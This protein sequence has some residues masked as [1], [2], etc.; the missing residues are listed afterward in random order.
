MS[1]G[2]N[3]VSDYSLGLDSL[4]GNI[5]GLSD[6]DEE[7][8]TQKKKKRKTINLD[9]FREFAAEYL[10]IRNMEGRKVKFELN[11]VQIFLHAILDHITNDLKKPIRVVILK[12]R[13]EGISLYTLGRFFW[14]ISTQENRQSAIITHDPDSTAELFKNS[15]LFHEWLPEEMKG[16]LSYDNKNELAYQKSKSSIRVGTANK[17]HYGSG[18]LLNYVHVSEFG[19]MA[20]NLQRELMAS[21]FQCV[22]ES[23]GTEILVES[24]ACGYT[25]F[26]NLFNGAR[27]NYN[28]ELEDGKPVLVYRENKDIP[29]DNVWA[30]VFFPYYAFSAYKLPVKGRLIL[31]EEE[32]GLRNA[33]GLTDEHI[34]WRR[35]AIQNK[36]F[37]DKT[38][39]KQEYPVDSESCFLSSGGAPVFDIEAIGTLRR[40]ALPPICEY[41]IDT[42][43]GNFVLNNGSQETPLGSLLVWQEPKRQSVYFIGADPSEGIADGSRSS[44]HVIERRSGAVVATWHGRITPDEFGRIL[45]Y[46]GAR[47]GGAQIACERNNMGILTNSILHDMNYPNIFVEMVPEAPNRSKKRYGWVTTK[48]SRPL[49]IGTLAAC[50]KDETF[51]GN[52]CIQDIGTLEEMLAFEQKED[53]TTGAKSGRRDDRV[54]SLAIA[55]HTALRQQ[56]SE[57]RRYENSYFALV[58]RPEPVTTAR[59]ANFEPDFSVFN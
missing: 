6:L 32:I 21:I 5:I 31:T 7:A 57:W 50:L 13:R 30:S 49:I 52:N 23:L 42:K 28:I 29:A 35:S 40:N 26:Y 46:L 12:A 55:M 56:P 59:E 3:V 47:Y 36:C 27:H 8:E 22:P 14:Q 19:K 45:F 34:N 43:L 11:E 37:G 39:F 20:P 15:K 25:E 33:Y 16:V 4:K 1:W 2:D 10:W 48:K 38:V 41:T 17:S 54:L 18:M 24:T 58:T 51:V 53:G 44:A 9:N